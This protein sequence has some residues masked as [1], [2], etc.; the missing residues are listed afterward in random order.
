MVA[1]QTSRERDTAGHGCAPC[2]SK[3]ECVRAVLVCYEWAVK[4]SPAQY[5]A[6]DLSMGLTRFLRVVG[7]SHRDTAK[8]IDDGGQPTTQTACL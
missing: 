1:Q 8:S 5:L 4:F 2:C 7:T 6:T 3:S